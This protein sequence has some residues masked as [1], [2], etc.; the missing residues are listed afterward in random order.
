MLRQK[1]NQVGLFFA[2]VV[3]A[4]CTVGCDHKVGKFAKLGIDFRGNIVYNVYM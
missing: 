4:G 1:V 2:F 3:C